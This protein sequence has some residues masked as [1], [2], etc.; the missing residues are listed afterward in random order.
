MELIKEEIIF[1]WKIIEVVQ[2]TVKIWDK[3]L[4]REIARRSPGVRLIITDGDKIL[5]TKEFRRELNAEDYRLPG[6]K[7][8]DTL[9]EYNK[10]KE[11]IDPHCLIAAKRECEEE[12]GLIPLDI[13]LFHISKVGTT[14]ERDLY[15]YVVTKFTAHE[16]WQHLELW[17]NIL[18]EWKTKDEVMEIIRQW[19]MQEDRS[20]GILMRFL[21]L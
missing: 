13:S 20:M 9:V 3:E 2:Q 6:G 18:V 17:E 8:F 10:H 16:K 15:Y 12:T 4:L 7:V 1:Q 21:S 14:M 11:N 19:W 5:L